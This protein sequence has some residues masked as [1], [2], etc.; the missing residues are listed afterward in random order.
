MRACSRIISPDIF[1]AILAWWCK[2]GG[3]KHAGRGRSARRQ[4]SLQC[5]SQGRHFDWHIRPR[6]GSG[7]AARPQPE[8]SIRLGQVHLAWLR[9]ELRQRRLPADRAARCRGEVCRGGASR[10]CTASRGRGPGPRWGH[11]RYRDPAAPDAGVQPQ[12]H[13]GLSGQQCDVPGHGTQRDRRALHRHFR[14]AVDAAAMAGI[15][16]GHAR[17]RAVCARDPPCG[18]SRR[19][20]G[21]GARAQRS[22]SRAGRTGGAARSAGPPF[23]GPAWS[24]A[25]GRAS[26]A[27]SLSR[28]SKRS[29]IPRR[30]R[31]AQARSAPDRRR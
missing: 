23:R 5:R 17:D 27:A 11:Q 24:S 19:A 9:V 28:C 14:L 29:A 10:G 13:P 16:I 26:A 12:G 2:S 18:F 4:L 31:P 7:R 1:R 30:G 21:A 22:G 8:H 20:D 3:A 6:S 15:A 25:R